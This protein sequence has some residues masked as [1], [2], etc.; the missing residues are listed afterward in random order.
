MTHCQTQVVE[1]LVQYLKDELDDA[2]TTANMLSVL[3]AIEKHYISLEI[4]E[5]T[6]IGVSLSRMQRRTESGTTS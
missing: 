1:E 2:K 4:L 3:D 5:K 6:R